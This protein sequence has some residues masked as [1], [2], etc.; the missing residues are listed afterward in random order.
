[1]DTF[2]VDEMNLAFDAPAYPGHEQL[3]PVGKPFNLP[4]YGMDHPA[5]QV[6]SASYYDPELARDFGHWS[7][8]RRGVGLGRAPSWETLYS[9]NQDPEM[10]RGLDWQQG[11]WGRQRRMGDQWW[12]DQ[13]ARYAYDAPFLD[14]YDQSE[15]WESQAG[16]AD[17][18]LDDQRQWWF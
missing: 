18:W 15:L 8:D 16:M 7:R 14:H 5:D 6:P 10:K 3:N 11:T 13:R 4:W 9:Y 2:S 17:S 12:G 1:M